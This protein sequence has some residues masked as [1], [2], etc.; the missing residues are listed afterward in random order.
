MSMRKA[1]KRG[2]NQWVGQL[3]FQSRGLALIEFVRGS[4]SPTEQKGIKVKSRRKVRVEVK[5]GRKYV[6]RGGFIA[7]TQ[8]RGIQVFKRTRKNRRDLLMQ[9]TPSLGQLL[10]RDTKNKIAATLQ[11]R[12]AQLF[13]KNFMQDLEFRVSDTFKRIQSNRKYK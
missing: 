5:P 9:T 13:R 4:K 3:E 1:E 11:T 7:R 6:V 8:A 10:L 2:A 12:G